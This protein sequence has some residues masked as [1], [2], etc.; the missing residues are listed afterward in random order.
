[1]LI[2]N[3]RGSNLQLS[4]KSPH[5]HPLSL[6]SEPTRRKPIVQQFPEPTGRERDSTAGI[7][8]PIND[9]KVHFEASWIDGGQLREVLADLC[10]STSEVP[11]ETEGRNKSTYPRELLLSSGSALNIH[12]IICLHATLI[13]CS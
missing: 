1:M 5:E 4:D 11:L 13:L 10:S 12:K 8:M 9:P 6:P 7:Y 3:T 2:S